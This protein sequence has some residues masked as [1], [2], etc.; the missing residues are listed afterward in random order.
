M[1]TEDEIR[2]GEK[3]G[4]PVLGGELNAAFA[5]EPLLR[6]PEDLVKLTAEEVAAPAPPTPS[7]E[8]LVK[9]HLLA[10]SLPS[11]YAAARTSYV[12]EEEN[13]K[14]YL[15]EKRVFEELASVIETAR[16]E[17]YDELKRAFAAVPEL[18]VWI[19]VTD[20]AVE[21]AKRVAGFVAKKI[22]EGAAKKRLDANAAKRVADRV[23]VEAWP[24]YLEPKNAKELL[25]K[26]VTKL[27]EDKEELR[28][29][30]EKA[31]KEV[32]KRMLAKKLDETD[33]LIEAFENRLKSIKA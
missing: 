21:E 32:V 8:E 10:F 33:E 6:L 26:A 29:R 18:G 7:R 12:I 22:V 25:A 16:R 23:R 27:S 2:K 24:I 5:S 14:H 20:A 30:I 9:L 31:E 28:E 17:A 11:R 1:R 3:A 15:V 19:A 13:G 4:E